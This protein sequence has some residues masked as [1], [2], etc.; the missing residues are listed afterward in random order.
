MLVIEGSDALGKTTF[1]KKIVRY[2]MDHDKYPCMYSWMTR[3]NEATFDFFE[4][5]KMWINPYTVQDRFHL[6]ALAYHKDKLPSNRIHTVN[7][8]IY[9]INGF[10]V[11]L[12]AEDEK[13]Y[14]EHINQDTRGNLLA[15]DILCKA[16]S[17]FK[18]IG[19]SSHRHHPY[20][21]FNVCN[22]FV[23]D[24]AVERIAECWM[25]QRR[26]HI[27]KLL[28]KIKTTRILEEQEKY[29]LEEYRKK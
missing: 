10:I 13:W 11:V 4:S 16:N 24:D 3:P 20:F 7:D 8:W 12:Y 5:Y 14:R 25:R 15:N 9:G 22:G 6:G 23:G 29:L 27:E 18:K 26:N 17:I 1:A 2:V 19:R 21:S 28:F